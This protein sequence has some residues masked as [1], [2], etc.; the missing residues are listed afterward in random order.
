MLWLSAIEGEIKLAFRWKGGT[1][2]MIVCRRVLVR[3]STE[4]M[5]YLE[6][7]ATMYIDDLFYKYGTISAGNNQKEA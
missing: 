2:G 4:H 3:L 5:M 6:V 1:V 7:F